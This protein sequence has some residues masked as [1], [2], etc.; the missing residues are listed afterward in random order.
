MNKMKAFVLLFTEGLPVTFIIRGTLAHEE[1]KK[2]TAFFTSVKHA[3]G[4]NY[5][6]GLP[7]SVYDYEASANQV[8]RFLPVDNSGLVYHTNHSLVNHDVKPWFE[9]YHKRVLAGETKRGNSETRFASL[10]QR[11]NVPLENIS[12]DVFKA[13]LRSKD[14]ER[15]PVC[16]AYKENGHGFTFSSVIFSLGKNASVQVTNGSPDVSEYQQYYFSSK[17]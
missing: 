8:T 6:I 3:A 14:N 5:L 7:D 11:L 12:V 2:A 16:N 10:E 17:Q 1:P 9:N 13:T 4:Q 15:S